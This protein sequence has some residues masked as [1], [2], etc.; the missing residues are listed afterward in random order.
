MAKVVV[1][2]GWPDGSGCLQFTVEVD[3][4][5]PDALDQAKRTALDGYAEA[6]IV[7]L[8]AEAEDDDGD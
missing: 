2:R 7:T 1:Y 4:S 5:Y 8:K 3:K 6:L